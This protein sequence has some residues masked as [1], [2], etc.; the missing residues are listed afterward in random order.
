MSNFPHQDAFGQNK[1][2]EE[3][4]EDTVEFVSWIRVVQ[5][6]TLPVGITTLFPHALIENA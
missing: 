5:I 6:P 1:A 3:S 2:R 4:P